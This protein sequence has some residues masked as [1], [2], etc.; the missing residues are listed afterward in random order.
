MKGVIVLRVE[1]EVDTPT[2]VEC[3]TTDSPTYPQI[4]FGASKTRSNLPQERTHTKKAPKT[5]RAQKETNQRISSLR[6]WSIC[7]I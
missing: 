3:G 7:N 6:A 5:A 2:E 4:L 1:V